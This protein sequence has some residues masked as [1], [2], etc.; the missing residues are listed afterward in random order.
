MI[1]T[2][3]RSGVKR[4]TANL[5]NLRYQ[6]GVNGQSWCGPEMVTSLGVAAMVRSGEMGMKE[7]VQVRAS[8][9]SQAGS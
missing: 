7:S 5:A 4:I 8:W 6:G 2:K 3:I 9:N 1:S